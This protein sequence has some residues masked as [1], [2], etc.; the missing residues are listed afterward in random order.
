M[1]GGCAFFAPMPGPAV[2][3]ELGTATAAARVAY[4]HGQIPIAMQLYGR[5]LDRARAMDDPGAIGNAEYN[6]AI[7]L[8]ATR[9]Y[10]AARGMLDD[11]EHDLLRAN[12]DAAEV[13]LVQAKVA[14]LEGKAQ[15]SALLATRV[16]SRRPPA[17]SAIRLQ[18]HLLRGLL[19]VDGSN[20]V[21]AEKAFR[22]AQN[23]AA[24]VKD[25][26]S[27]ARVSELSGRVSALK[28]EPLQAA[29]AFDR[30]ASLLRDARIFVDVPAA[31]ERAGHAY[32][33]AGRQQAAA[34]R[35]LRAARTLYGQGD[36][37]ESLKVASAA[38]VAAMAAEDGAVLR[39][40]E[41]FAE[42]IRSSRSSDV[43]NRAE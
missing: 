21:E 15:E 11:A 42:E 27:Q 14:R 33:N 20:T 26:Q 23:L 18:A 12:A 31:L 38:R 5:A 29:L 37:P 17:T 35:L 13:L 8:T 30:E 39:S 43:G 41:R 28:N 3:P 1:L 16:L 19:A 9:N 7:C 2:D 34:D 25:A 4:A 24:Q 22:E 6:L 32:E 40:I 36:R 10:P